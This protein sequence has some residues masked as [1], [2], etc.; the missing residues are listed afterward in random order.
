MKEAVM[1]NPRKDPQ[2]GDVLEHQNGER[3]TVVA[4]Q[5]EGSIHYGNRDFKMVS[6]CS[7]DEWH[8]WAMQTSILDF[9]Q[10]EIPPQKIS[11]PI[12]AQVR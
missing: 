9:G 6:V 10:A 5:D 2:K 4:R 1:R 3:R 7:L 12:A 11:T 8:E